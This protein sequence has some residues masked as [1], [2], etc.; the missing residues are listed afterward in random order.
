MFV[1]KGMDTVKVYEQ[2]HA[3]KK[4]WELGTYYITREYFNEK[5]IGFEVMPGDII[6]SCAG[7]I[8]E[9]YIMPDEIEL[10]LKRL[11]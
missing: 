3:I 11:E 1:Q 10:L 9:T 5:M 4:D 2:Q 7:T 6:V 8:G